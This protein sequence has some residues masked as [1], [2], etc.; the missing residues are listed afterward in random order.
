MLVQIRCIWGALGLSVGPR[1]YREQ[2]A[3]IHPLH[4]KKQKEKRENGGSVTQDSVRETST[5]GVSARENLIQGNGY[6]GD[7]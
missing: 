6:M 5:L 3:G 7:G 4:H 1:A 2:D